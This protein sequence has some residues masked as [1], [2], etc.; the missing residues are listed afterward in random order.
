MEALSC[1]TT[2]SSSVGCSVSLVH[3][4]LLK[5]DP[6][7]E[8]VILC[9]S[10]RDGSPGVLRKPLCRRAVTQWLNDSSLAVMSHLRNEQHSDIKPS[11]I[12]DINQ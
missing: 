3:V 7:K 6:I 2:Q 9:L 8:R 12:Y 10:H 1:Q 4:F 11:S 5:S